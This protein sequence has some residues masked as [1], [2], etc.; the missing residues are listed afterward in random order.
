MVER[1]QVLLEN[2]ELDVKELN[3]KVNGLIEK[4]DK[5]TTK[6][7]LIPKNELEEIIT[8]SLQNTFH[9]NKKINL[10]VSILVIGIVG[11]MLMSFII[12]TLYFTIP[13]K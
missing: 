12:W 9:E 8:R 3:K 6:P 11:L 1:L 5:C 4:F 7:Y 10:M 2:M 13:I